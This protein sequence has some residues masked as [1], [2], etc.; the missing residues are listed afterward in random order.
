MVLGQLDALTE[1]NETLPP[2]HPTPQTK[3]NSRWI[4]D[5]TMK[6]KTIKLLDQYRPRENGNI[7]SSVL[8]NTGN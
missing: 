6:D 1:K 8:F 2:P 4:V 3:I 7:L 5:L